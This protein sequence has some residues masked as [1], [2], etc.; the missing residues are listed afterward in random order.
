M[1]EL[2]NIAY[3][4]AA[5]SLSEL[6]RQKISLEAPKLELYPLAEVRPALH[7]LYDQEVWSV[8]QIFSGGMSGHAIL[9]VDEKSAQ[10][11]GEQVLHEQAGSLDAEAL[12][13]V[14]RE[15]GNIVLQ[16]ALGICGEL[17]HFKVAFAVPGLRVDTLGSMLSSM[18]VEEAELQYALM[19]RTKFQ[20]LS[21]HVSGN[22]VVVLGVTSF[23]RLIE[24]T[25]D[26]EKR[27]SGP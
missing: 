2:I 9:L 25:N 20:I 19:V 17:L 8:H 11:L 16:A 21:K 7:Q 6:T 4:R 1:A 18:L 26:W 27:L 3:G 24:A 22:M 15:I 23:N 5:A 13:D 10:T 14:L 12:Q